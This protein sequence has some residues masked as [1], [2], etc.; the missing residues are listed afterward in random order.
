MS[1]WC[2]M[3]WSLKPKSQQSVTKTCWGRNKKS[4][5]YSPTHILLK[6]VTSKFQNTEQ[7]DRKVE[8]L[9]PI[10]IQMRITAF[11]KLF[12]RHYIRHLC[13]LNFSKFPRLLFSVIWNEKT[14]LVFLKTKLWNK[15]II[16][17]DQLL[18][19]LWRN[20]GAGRAAL[21][22][23]CTPWAAGGW[24]QAA[25]S[26]LPAPAPDSMAAFL[27]SPSQDRSHWL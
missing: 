27:K 11:R 14:Y 8:R 5:I 22:Q 13:L 4:C 16:S 6:F 10:L 24:A 23:S 25:P 26:A 12:L 2:L 7:W 9:M 17:C 21:P 1:Y 15:C 19:Q 18:N 3:C 20:K